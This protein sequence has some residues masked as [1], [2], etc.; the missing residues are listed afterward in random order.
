MIQKKLEG[1]MTT[2]EMFWFGC[3][4]G[5]FIVAFKLW[6]YVNNLPPGAPWPR[7][8]FKTAA[9]AGLALAFPIAAGFLSMVCEPHQKLIAVFEGA[10]APTLFLVLADH[11]RIGFPAASNAGKG[12]AKMISSE[13]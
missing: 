8:T 11:F 12:S 2:W 13:L 7:W 1:S 4:G 5:C 10:S 3:L 6:F 9:C